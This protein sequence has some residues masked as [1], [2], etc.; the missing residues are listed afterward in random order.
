M[1]AVIKFLNLLPFVLFFMPFFQLCTLPN[2]KDNAVEVDLSKLKETEKDTIVDKIGNESIKHKERI[3]CNVNVYRMSFVFVN[4]D[5]QSLKDP[6]FYAFLC[7]TFLV[8][9]SIFSLFFAI[10]NKFNLVFIC[11]LV[12]LSLPIIS[13][14]ILYFSNYIDEEFELKYG[15]YLFILNILLIIYFSKRHL[16]KNLIIHHNGFQKQTVL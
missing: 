15:F 9:G 11:S 13:L 12:N 16:I 14:S 10:K 7:F 2:Y 3:G 4:M 6:L 5:F 1:K 8:L